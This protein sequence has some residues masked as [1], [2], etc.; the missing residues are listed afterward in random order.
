MRARRE[1]LLGVTVLADTKPCCM[2]R[3]REAEAMHE[4]F[5]G[6]GKSLQCILAVY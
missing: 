5:A 3:R 6:K 4:F 2:T 1:L